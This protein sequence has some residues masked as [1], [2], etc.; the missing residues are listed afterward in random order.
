MGDPTA[1]ANAIAEALVTTVGGLTVSI[2]SLVFHNVFNNMVKHRINQMEDFT[3][4]IMLT[5]KGKDC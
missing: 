5:V 1:L 3:T 2:P 4:K